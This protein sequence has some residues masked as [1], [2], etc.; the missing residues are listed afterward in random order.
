MN[1]LNFSISKIIKSNV[2]IIVSLLFSFLI[3]SARIAI[4]KTGYFL[5]LVWNIFLAII[6]FLITMHLSN[7]K[8]TSKFILYFMFL[9]W[10]LFLPNAPYIIT[11]LFHL[12][13]STY[14]LIWLDTLVITSFA[15]T[16]M[17]LFYFSLAEMLTH[18]KQHYSLKYENITVC[19]ICVL[20]AFGIYLGRFLRYNSW[21]ILSNPEHLFIDVFKILLQPKIHIEAWIFTI[22]FSVFL[23]LG[24]FIFKQL[25]KNGLY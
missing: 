18:L 15:F 8:R 13:R 24:Y 19:I 2:A 6:P 4:T 21:E 23:M 9:I 22:L 7:K 5:F 17:L 20:S 11:D 14:H 12:K 16:G 10:L 3:L 25:G 1:I